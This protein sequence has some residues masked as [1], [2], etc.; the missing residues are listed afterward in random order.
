MIGRSKNRLKSGIIEL[1][2]FTTL[3]E[4]NNE[5]RKSKIPIIQNDESGK[6]ELVERLDH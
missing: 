5:R 4:I 6:R 3:Y 1:H 2:F